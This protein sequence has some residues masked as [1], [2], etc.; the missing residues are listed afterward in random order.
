M[1]RHYQ[2]LLETAT[3][4]PEKQLSELAQ[5]SFYN[6]FPLLRYT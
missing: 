6:E 5:Y 4:D 3:A 2:A 1:V